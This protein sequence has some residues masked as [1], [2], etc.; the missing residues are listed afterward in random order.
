MPNSAENSVAYR[1][2]TTPS[3]EYFLLENRQR[4]KFDT[5]IPGSGLIIYHVHNGVNL[6]GNCI[7]CTHPQ[8]MYPVCA[9]ATVQV[10]NSTP[11]SYGSINGSRCPWPTTETS[12]TPA[13]TEF[14]DDSTPCMRSWS[15]NN[16]GKPISNIT[17]EGGLISFEFMKLGIDDATE[18][19]YG[20]MKI[21]PN[22]ANEYIDIQFSNVFK[23]ENIDF[24]NVTGQ[25]VM[26]TPYYGEYKDGIMWQRISIADLCKGF[27]IVRVGN[28]VAKLVVH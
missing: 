3:N 25:L 13:Q 21:V 4:I 17:H 27:Y 12:S 6:V 28:E 19:N 24:Y 18:A 14:T 1:I 9:N 23:F 26:S 16:T 10:P 22:P 5:N 15:G 20:F 8:R 11:S 2:N 7:N